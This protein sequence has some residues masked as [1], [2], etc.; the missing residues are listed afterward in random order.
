MSLQAQRPLTRYLPVRNEH[1][2][3]RSHIETAGHQ[4]ELLSSH[5]VLNSSSCRGYLHKL[6]GSGSSKFRPR[7]ANWNKRWFVFDR[8]KRTLVYY[9]DKQEGKA[10]GGIYFQVI[11]QVSK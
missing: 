6:A 4:I 1:F 3:L 2:D 7:G 9:Q 10:K 11:M 5:I 8:N